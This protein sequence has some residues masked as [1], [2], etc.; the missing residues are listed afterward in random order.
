MRSRIDSPSRRDRSTLRTATVTSAAPDAS[1]A[2]RAIDMLGYFPVPTIRRD[3]K[4]RPAMVSRLFSTVVLASTDE[5]D[6]LEHVSLPDFDMLELRPRDNPPVQLDG[7]A[8]RG[9][10]H[11]LEQTPEGVALR[12]LVLTA[13]E[14]D[15]HRW[16]L[17]RG[18][19][20]APPARQPCGSRRSPFPPWP[21]RPAPRRRA[22]R[23]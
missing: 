20:H 1:M 22:R 8:A 23:P 7:H 19:R 15:P 10:T 18:R 12:C 13:V 16:R 3:A 14:P 2:S 11:R 5:M 6:H 9:Q 17:S 4:V 21:E